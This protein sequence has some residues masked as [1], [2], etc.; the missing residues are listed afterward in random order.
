MQSSKKK[1]FKVQ[2][3]RKQYK[4]NKINHFQSSTIQ[5]VLKGNWLIIT[6]KNKKK[7][8]K[9]KENIC[10]YGMNQNYLF[11]W[12]EPE[13]HRV[14]DA[15]INNVTLKSLKQ[16]YIQQRSLSFTKTI[17]GFGHVYRI[18]VYGQTGTELERVNLCWSKPLS[19][20]MF[21][22]DTQKHYKNEMDSLI[23][24]L[25]QLLFCWFNMLIQI[26]TSDTF[27]V[28]KILIP[29]PLYLLLHLSLI[30]Y[31]SMLK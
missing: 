14:R 27:L 24:K 25:Q 30:I 26:L 22:D 4:S 28:L 18:Y 15:W 6:Y 7:S 20:Q 1:N 10:L 13:L 11:I 8:V 17:F 3:S 5:T 29:I 2:Y 19:S 23:L 12:Y 31:G 9:L 21:C 16:K